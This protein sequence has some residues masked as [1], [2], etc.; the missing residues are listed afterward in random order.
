MSETASAGVDP[1]AAAIAR[2][3][4]RHRVRLVG[5]FVP[6]LLALLIYLY[7]RIAGEDYLLRTDQTYFTWVFT[8]VPVALIGFSGLVL[9]MIYLQTGF[10]SRTT[11][12]Y[13]F[14][15][16]FHADLDKA[17]VPALRMMSEGMTALK[18]RLDQLADE[19][20]AARG[21][22]QQLKLKTRLV[23][24]LEAGEREELVETLRGQLGKQAAAEVLD[25]IKSDVATSMK[26][27]TRDTE[28]RSMFE[29]SKQRLSRELSN[30]G[31]R[32]NLNLTLGVGTTVVGLALL[33]WA[34]FSEVAGSL[35]P[36]PWTALAVH[37]VPRLSLVILI[38]LFAYFFLSLY[39]TTLGEIKYFQ[40]E[41][42]NV[43]AK[44]IALR[45]AL[46]NED[47]TTLTAAV[48]AL[49][50]TERN[51]ILNK[52]QTTVEL[53]KAKIDRQGMG[54]VLKSLTEVLKKLEK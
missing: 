54:D 41:L 33:G 24:R 51:H 21:E 29:D 17:E 38:E 26:R 15:S 9:T 16:N 36:D 23:D 5:V 6:L 13:E 49:S 11:T 1:L 53:E 2:E 48:N 47:K 35:G 30:L 19:Q 31:R 3:E 14:E 37:F 52:D 32:G 43:E 44:Q 25:Q 12:V 20:A 39:K 10:R 7:G 40:N 45:T 4:E 46:D 22:V 34:V 8:L 42:T 18:Q 50:A 27:T 28:L